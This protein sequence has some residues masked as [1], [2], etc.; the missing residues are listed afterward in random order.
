MTVAWLK[1]QM[2]EPTNQPGGKIRMS[3]YSFEIWRA[4][5]LEPTKKKEREVEVRDLTPKGAVKGGG[6]NPNEDEK[7]AFRRTG[8][9]DFMK[10]VN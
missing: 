3:D 4:R 7:H 2:L 6:T 1:A 10:G 9:I 8:E 5:E